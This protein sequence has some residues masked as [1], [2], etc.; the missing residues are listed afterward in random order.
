MLLQ[1]L[2][3]LW[4]RGEV[5][6]EYTIYCIICTTTI[7]LKKAAE[8]GQALMIGCAIFALRVQVL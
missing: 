8:C 4:G 6:P 2:Q 7:K 3:N 5:N 1:A